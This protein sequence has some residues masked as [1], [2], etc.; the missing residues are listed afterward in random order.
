MNIGCYLVTDGKFEQAFIPQKMLTELLINLRTK[1]KEF[2]HFSERTIEVEGVY[3][4]A[5]GS[6]TQLMCLDVG[7]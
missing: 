7:E 5:K 4:P 1:G 2:V 6:K 3:I